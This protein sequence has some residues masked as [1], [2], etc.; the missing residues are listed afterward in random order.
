MAVLVGHLH[1]NCLFVNVFAA[2]SWQKP[3]QVLQD[4]TEEFGGDQESDCIHELKT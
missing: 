2:T 4:F 1:N 3:K